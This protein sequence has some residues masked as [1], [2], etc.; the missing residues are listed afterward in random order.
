MT[1]SAMWWM[2]RSREKSSSTDKIEGRIAGGLWRGRFGGRCSDGS[3]G[4]VDAPSKDWGGIH[5]KGLVS[6]EDL[7]LR[8]GTAPGASLSS[9][10][11]SSRESRA[12]DMAGFTGRVRLSPCS[13]AK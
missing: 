3:P 5:S 10:V 6:V 12:S 7:R 13:S 2:D 9:G 4:D 11:F 8:L 1:E